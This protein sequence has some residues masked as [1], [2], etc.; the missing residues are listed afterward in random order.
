MYKNAIKKRDKAKK[1]RDS[2]KFLT[3]NQDCPSKSETVGG[4]TVANGVTRYISKQHM[5]M[6]KIL[7]G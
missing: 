2:R 6:I 5:P 1:E 7:T 4:Y 3:Q